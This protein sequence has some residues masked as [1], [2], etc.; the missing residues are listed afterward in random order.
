M[1]K[2]L[3]LLSGK[4]VRRIGRPK[5]KKREEEAVDDS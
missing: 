3:K 5:G 2:A 4:K 1:N